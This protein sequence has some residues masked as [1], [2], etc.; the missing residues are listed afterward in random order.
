MP[1]V[2]LKD[3]LCMIPFVWH[4]GKGDTAGTETGQ[5]FLDLQGVWVGDG[6]EWVS[7][8]QKE[9]WRSWNHSAPGVWR[10]LC[11]YMHLPNWQSYAINSFLDFFFFKLYVN[12]AQGMSGIFYLRDVLWSLASTAVHPSIHLPLW[13]CVRERLHTQ[14]NS[15]QT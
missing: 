5:W 8:E 7:K 14:F 12:F 9:T 2:R 6:G 13:V 11:N 1:D 4:C 15:Q 10:R 3:P